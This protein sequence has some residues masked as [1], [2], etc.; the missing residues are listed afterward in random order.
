MR[1]L[2]VDTQPAMESCRNVG[3]VAGLVQTCQL[4]AQTA[5]KQVQVAKPRRERPHVL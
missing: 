3:F 2:D 5:T 4:I 1:I